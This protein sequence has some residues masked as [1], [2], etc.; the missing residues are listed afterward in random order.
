MN[1]NKKKSFIKY[2]ELSGG[3]AEFRKFVKEN[4]VYPEDAL[5]NKVEGIV[6][7]TY[8]VNDNGDVFNIKIEKGIGYGCDEEAIRLIGLLRFKKVKNR[9]LRV[10]SSKKARINF[11]IAKPIPPTAST[12]AYEFKPE[13][14]KNSKPPLPPAPILYSYS[15]KLNS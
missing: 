14:K 2:P 7:L 11:S 3:S 9:G 8:E 5:K 10:K 13:V 12:V 6:F 15:I 4:L 1:P